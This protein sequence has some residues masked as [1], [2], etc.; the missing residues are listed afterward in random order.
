[1]DKADLMNVTEN[2]TPSKRYRRVSIN[3]TVNTLRPYLEN[4]PKSKPA[5]HIK[6]GTPNSDLNLSAVSKDPDLFRASSPS[7]ILA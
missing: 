7:E 2:N 6:G 3:S 4:S 5:I 1:M